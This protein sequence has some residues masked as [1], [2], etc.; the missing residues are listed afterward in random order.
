MIRVSSNLTLVLKIFI[1]TMW[2][3]FFGMLTVAILLADSGDN[4]LFGNPIFK[5]GAALFFIFFF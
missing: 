5:L 2:I 1:P 3:V 4:P